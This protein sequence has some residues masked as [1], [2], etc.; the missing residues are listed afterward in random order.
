M[1]EGAHA[2][3]RRR[4]A[5]RARRGRLAAL[6]HHAARTPGRTRPTA[7]AGDLARDPKLVAPMRH[8]RRARGQRAHPRGRARDLGGAARQ[9]AAAARAPWSRCA[10]PATRSCSRTATAPRSALLALQQEHGEP[11]GAAAAVRRAGRDDAGAD[12]LPAAGRARRRRPGPADRAVLTRARGRPR[13]PG[14]R[15]GADQAH[16]PVLRRDRGAP[17]RR[18]AR[19]GRRRP[20]PAAAGGGWSPS[21]RPV[22][23]LEHEQIDAAV[24]PRLGG[25]RR[26]RR[27]HPGRAA[28]TAGSPASRPSS[29][30]TAARPSSALQIGADLLMLT[31]GVPRVVVRLRHP[32]AARHG[33][34]HR[35]RRRRATCATATS[36]PA[37]WAPRSSRRCAS[38]RPAGRA[39]DHR[40]GP[41]R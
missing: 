21:P 13:R 8:P 2:V 24:R 14:V 11:R 25:D 41:S 31:T 37:A 10:R 19:L 7:G 6:P 32:L 1:L 18:R 4:R 40:P 26:R 17:A 3:R 9:R 30:R 38:S 34:P 39:V 20:T 33:A 12:R 27:R 29:T 15:R 16:R 5:A 36:R 23:V 22:E 28:P 35:L